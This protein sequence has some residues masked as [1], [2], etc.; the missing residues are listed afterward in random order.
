MY[1]S[2]ATKNNEGDII[3]K[4]LKELYEVDDA[5]DMND[6]RMQLLGEECVNPPNKLPNRRVSGQNWWA[7]GHLSFVASLC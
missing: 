7:D 1:T 4:R 2:L 3:E 5:E 6:L